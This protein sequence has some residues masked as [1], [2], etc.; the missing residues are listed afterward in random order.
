MVGVICHEHV[1]GVRNWT[2]DEEAFG[3]ILSGL[4]SVTV[5]QR[6][7]VRGSSG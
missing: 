5:E 7:L 6:A 3:H 4:V 1:G 2:P